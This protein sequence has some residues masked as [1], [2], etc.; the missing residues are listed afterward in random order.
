MKPDFKFSARL[1]AVLERENLTYE[2]MA[3]EAGTS[4]GPVK[5]YAEETPVSKWMDSKVHK[6][7]SVVNKYELKWKAEEERKKGEALQNESEAISRAARKTTFYKRAKVVHA[8]LSSTIMDDAEKQ[9]VIA[10]FMD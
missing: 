2:R 1:R 6:V 7:A 9:E 3:L 8:I 4:V 10:Q 5:I